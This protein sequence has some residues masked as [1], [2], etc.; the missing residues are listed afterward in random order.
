MSQHPQIRPEV[1]NDINIKVRVC[2]AEPSERQ[3]VSAVGCGSHEV[4]FKTRRTTRF[5]ILLAAFAI[6]VK[7]DVN[8]F[9]FSYDGTQ[10]NGHDTPGSLDMEDNGRVLFI[11]TIDVMILQIS[12]SISVLLT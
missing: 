3:F 4:Y 7:K 1:V 10:I 12:Y 11:C 8:H 2:R 6:F 5:S 9:R